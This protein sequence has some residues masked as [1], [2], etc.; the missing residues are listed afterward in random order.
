[1]A[2]QNLGAQNNVPG[3]QSRM[4]VTMNNLINQ[5]VNITQIL[6]VKVSN[7]VNKAT[8]DKIRQTIHRTIANAPLTQPVGGM[9]VTITWHTVTTKSSAYYYTIAP[10]VTDVA[11]TEHANQVFARLINTLKIQRPEWFAHNT[12]L[13]IIVT[14]PLTEARALP[15]ALVP[16][17]QG[18]VP[19]APINPEEEI[20]VNIVDDEDDVDRD[21]DED[22]EM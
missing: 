16:P 11:V 15:L 14:K 9:H 12:G 1:M 17:I 20:H 5:G 22:D 19:N 18:I 8:G 21:E 13:A 2:Q 10:Y 7:Q 3:R 6:N 4:L